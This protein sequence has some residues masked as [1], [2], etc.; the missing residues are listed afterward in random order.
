MLER[1]WNNLERVANRT[2][3]PTKQKGGPMK[4][5]GIVLAGAVVA[6]QLTGQ[7]ARAIDDTNSLETIRE[8]Q[9]RITELEKEVRA[10]QQQR[11]GSAGTNDTRAVMQVEGADLK[12]AAA[13]TAP[14]PGEALAT[15]K[16]EAP[17]T[18]SFG[19]DGF[20]MT[21]ADGDFGIR[22]GCVLQVDSRTFFDD[23]GTVGNDG[24][25]LRRARPVV[26]G[27]V[28]H[29]FD[30]L[31]VPDFGTGSNGGNGGT[32]PT[33]QIFDAYLNYHPGVEFQL[34]AGKFKSP[35]GLEQLQ[36]D[37]DITFN[38]R[39]LVTDLVPTR[40]LGVALHGELFGGIASYA[41]GIFNGSGDY[42]LSSNSDFEDSKA[43]AGRVFLRPFRGI[44]VPALSGL[45]M[46]VGG[47][48]ED[49]Q[50][51][52]TAGLPNT[53]GGTTPGYATAGQQQFFAYRPGVV[54]QGLHWRLSPQGYWYVGPFGLL[55]EYAISNQ[56]VTLTGA[57]GQPAAHLNHT[58]WQ[59]TGAWM[60]T[61]ED[62]TYGPVAPH[63]PF[64]L[65]EGGWGAFQ[66]AGRYSELNIDHAAFPVFADPTSSA[67]S[68]YEWSVGLNWYL[69]RNVR[70]D[71]SYSQTR[72][73]GGGGAGSSPPATVTQKPEKVLFTRMQLAF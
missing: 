60:L 72:F 5:R 45:G 6:A 27:T 9:K 32:A 71:F 29:D 51:T 36:A 44:S 65:R 14:E 21:T 55:G 73:E 16:V 12:A 69:N 38:E 56:R 63:R 68:A 37:R 53:T 18:I 7:S 2:Q 31:F 23:H 67:S 43:F 4:L 25:L 20:T 48:Y 70:V 64:N 13:K 39:S 41:A 42:R 24:F 22:F 50:A 30:V 49:L 10:L 61:G 19:S 26:G 15:A 1:R 40:D 62:A 54:A 3:I 17:P 34:E 47:S 66:L 33:P 11:A 59:V 57:G 52:N 58:A 35:V 28:F 8:L 46:G